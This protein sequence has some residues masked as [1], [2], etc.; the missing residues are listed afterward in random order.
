MNNQQGSAEEDGVE[1]PHSDGNQYFT[2]ERLDANK[3]IVEIPAEQRSVYQERLPSGFDP[4]GEIY[5]RGQAYRRL[6]GGKAKWWVLISGWIIFG[7][8]FVILLLATFSSPAPATILPLIFSCF[9]VFLVLKG[10]LKKI[11][12]EKRRKR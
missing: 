5:L 8:I 6:S 10:T 9:P 2:H 12:E 3:I 7:G 1:H 11:A 4:M